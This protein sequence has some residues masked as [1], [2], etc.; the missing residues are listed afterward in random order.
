MAHSYRGVIV[1]RFV[2]CR[3]RFGTQGIHFGVSRVNKLHPLSTW[4]DISRLQDTPLSE[5][6]QCTKETLLTYLEDG[7]LGVLV[8][9][10]ND[11]AV[12]HASQMLN[13]SANA[14]S[15]IEVGS[16]NLSSLANLQESSK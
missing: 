8:N 7:C 2:I 12:L 16:D 11:L 10:N 4:A 13:G 15:N 1:R 14:H 6:I 5:K 3:Y 9:G